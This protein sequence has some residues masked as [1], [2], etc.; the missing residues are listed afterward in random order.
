MEDLVIE[1]FIKAPTIIADDNYISDGIVLI[2]KQYLDTALL[3]A[4]K[5]E[6]DNIMRTIPF[7]KGDEIDITSINTPIKLLRNNTI[8]IVLNENDHCKYYANYDIV[9]MFEKLCPYIDIYYTILDN[10]RTKIIKVFREP[11]SIDDKD[12]F[13]GCFASMISEGVH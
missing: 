6:S 5:N 4:V 13:I 8:G 7:E 9:K 10:G 11:D 2:N 1:R 12:E 3:K